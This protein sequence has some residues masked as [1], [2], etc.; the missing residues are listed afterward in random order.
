MNYRIKKNL[1]GLK[2]SSHLIEIE[3]LKPIGNFSIKKNSNHF[4]YSSHSIAFNRIL[5][6][7][8][9]RIQKNLLDSKH[10]S[11]SIAID[12]FQWMRTLSLKKDSLLL[13]IVF[14]FEGNTRFMVQFSVSHWKVLAHNPIRDCC[15]A[16][17]TLKS[18]ECE[19]I[20]LN[21]TFYAGICHD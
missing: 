6:N 20:L 10:S 5:L 7:D 13:L 16:D 9:S 2:Y 3:T 19:T 21:M 17:F 15:K 14:E 12:A 1:L 4:K 8:N 11:H 18:R